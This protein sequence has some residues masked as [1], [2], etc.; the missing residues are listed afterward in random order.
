M[1]FIKY[2]NCLLLNNLEFSKEKVLDFDLKMEHF[3]VAINNSRL[4]ANQASALPLKYQ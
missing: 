3:Y 1:L 4:S 2:L